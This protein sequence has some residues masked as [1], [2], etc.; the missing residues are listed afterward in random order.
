MS[1]IQPPDPCATSMKA[2]VEALCQET[3]EGATW[4][5]WGNYAIELLILD[6]YDLAMSGQQPLND[7]QIAKAA[8]KSLDNL[9]RPFGRLTHA[10]NA[11]I[12]GGPEAL[13]A[14]KMERWSPQESQT[15]Y[16]KFIARQFIGK[17]RDNC[18]PPDEPP[19][20]NPLFVASLS[21]ESV[22]AI[23][24][25][26]LGEGDFRLGDVA[27]WAIA[28]AFMVLVFLSPTRWLPETAFPGLPTTI[29]TPWGCRKDRLM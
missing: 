8:G 24:A 2:C 10:R 9:T 23:E 21:P 26:L 13:D 11:T 12:W 14:A 29:D 15:E 3:R 25:A 4:I 18:R 5:S 6:N 27:A 17:N 19:T 22:A 7:H 20:N 1:N 16:R 28:G